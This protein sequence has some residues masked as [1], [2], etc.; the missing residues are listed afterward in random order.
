M[1][2]NL[3]KAC[4]ADRCYLIICF[5]YGLLL[6]SFALGF[7]FYPH[8]ASYGVFRAMS[9]VLALVLVV[10][11]ELCNCIG[12][13]LVLY[14]TD[15]YNAVNWTSYVLTVLLGLGVIDPVTSIG[16]QCSAIAILAYALGVL[17][18]STYFPNAGVFV[19]M[20]GEYE[21][22]HAHVCVR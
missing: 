22:M 13:G 11:D 16:R 21:C 19:A 7:C 2:K 10:I 17:Q 1:V 6:A 15:S 9:V 3:C 20:I 14:V 8:N 5:T 18:Y 12:A 4:F